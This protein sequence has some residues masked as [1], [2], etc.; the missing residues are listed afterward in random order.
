MCLNQMVPFI[1]RAVIGPVRKLNEYLVA[2]YSDW[3]RF[4]FFFLLLLQSRL[5][6]F[7]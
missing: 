6:Q 1:H 4:N 3:K 5:K 2:L 7:Y